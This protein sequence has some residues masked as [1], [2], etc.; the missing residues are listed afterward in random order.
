MSAPE[1]WTT[2]PCDP[3]DGEL[4]C[5]EAHHRSLMGLATEAWQEAAYQRVVVGGELHGQQLGADHSPT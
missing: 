4:W 5:L 3:F 1:I 2:C